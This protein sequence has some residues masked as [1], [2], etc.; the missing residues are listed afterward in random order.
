MRSLAQR[1]ATA[2]REIKSLIEATLEKVASGSEHVKR[3]GGATH[4]IMTSV[5]RVSS[6]IAAITGETAQ[7]HQGIGHASA[8]VSELDQGAQQNAALAEQSAAAA[9]SLQDQAQRLKTLVERFRLEG[10][11]A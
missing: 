9:L 2:A 4:E 1:S 5:Q 8:S 11:P 7:Q 6:T 3:A 10:S